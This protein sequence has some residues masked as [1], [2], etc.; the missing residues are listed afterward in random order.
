M[1]NLQNVTISYQK[2]DI[3]P[4]N[5]RISDNQ[6]VCIIGSSGAGKSTLIKA[7][8]GVV[9]ISGG[10]II[11]N[12]KQLTKSQFTYITQQGTLFNHLTIK[13]NL[14][15]TVDVQEAESVLESLGL[16]IHVLSLYPFNLSGGE[17]QRIDLA[18]A[19]LSKVKLL[20]LD[21]AFNAL[22]SKTK[23]DTYEVVLKIQKQ[24]KILILMVTHDL[25]E[26]VF[27]ADQILLI[28]NGKIEFNGAAK[29]LVTSPNDYVNKLVSRKKMEMLRGFYANNA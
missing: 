22:D 12:D 5:L 23:D 16:T 4:F 25:Q 21:E 11:Y 20:F 27:L 3:G 1:L 8:A 10:K 24:Y 13:E 7:I 28:D 9:E 17:R 2:K 15:L 26:A 6:I 14:A 29:N 19:I 18:R